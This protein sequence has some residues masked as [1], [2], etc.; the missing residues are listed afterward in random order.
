MS[1]IISQLMGQECTIKIGYEVL[2]C[3]VIDADE[4]WIKILAHEKKED[5]MKYYRIADIQQIEQEKWAE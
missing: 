2:N 3:K 5:K 1:K 4:Q